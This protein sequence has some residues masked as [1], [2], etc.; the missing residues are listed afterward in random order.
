MTESGQTA[1]RIHADLTGFDAL[2]IPVCREKEGLENNTC[3]ESVWGR[4][5]G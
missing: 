1:G 4:E 5:E 2:F 3:I